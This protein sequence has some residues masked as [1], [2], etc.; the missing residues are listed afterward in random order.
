VTIFAAQNTVD[1]GCMLRSINRNS[2]AIAR[3]HARLAMASEA[4]LVLLEGLWRLYLRSGTGVCR[5]SD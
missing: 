2:F 1:A 3:C 4:A 5:G